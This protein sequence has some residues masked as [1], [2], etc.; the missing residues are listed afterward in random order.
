MII[1]FHT[2]IFP[3]EVKKRRTLYW[4][5]STWFSELYERKRAKLAT[6]EDLIAEMDGSGV[7]VSVACGFPWDDPVICHDCND[8]LLDAANRF[9]GRIVAFG[10]V[11]PAFP[12]QAAEE[13][14]RILSAGMRGIG[15]LN[16][17]GQ[18]FD[19]ADEL[20]LG[21]LVEVLENRDV[22]LMIHTS[23]PVG[24]Y[25]PGKGRTVP[26]LIFRLAKSWPDLKIVAAHWG[27]GL[28]F[29]ELMPEVAQHAKNIYYDAAASPYLYRADIFQAVLHMVDARRVLYGTDYPLIRQTRLLKQI[30]SLQL[31]SDVEA[32]IL[33]L[34]AVALLHLPAGIP[35]VFSRV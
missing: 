31:P 2:H 22:P 29:Y 7:D 12:Q 25:Y 21:P 11:S 30:R 14:E 8:Y 10:S 3:P 32:K 15:E 20:L 17:D 28:P 5:R 24:H 23:E 26:D 33:G 19:I 16:A 27:G 9:P 1:D 34:N 13:A 35:P 6:A 4:Q 18:G